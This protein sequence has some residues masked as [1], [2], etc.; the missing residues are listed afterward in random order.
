[1]KRFIYLLAAVAVTLLLNGCMGGAFDIGSTAP[2]PTNVRAIAGDSS[3]TLVWDTSPNHEYWL[4][5][6]PGTTVTTQNWDL[7]G[8]FAYPN[9]TSPYIAVNLT[10]GAPYAFTL[11]ARTKGGPGGPGSS[12][13]T[14]TPRLAGAAWNNNIALGNTDINAT[15]YGGVFVA[16]GQQGTIY[17]SP[18]FNAYTAVSWTAQANPLATPRPNLYAAIYGGAYVAAGAGGTLLY[19]TNATTWTQQTTGTSND[20]LGL[21][22]NG[23]GG[24]VAVG[25]NGTILTSVGGQTWTLQ[26]SGTSNDLYAISYGSGVWIAVGKSGA[27]LT[28]VNA[29]SWTPVVSGTGADINGITYG[30]GVDATTG[31]VTPMFIAVGAAGNQLTSTDNGATWRA[32]TI[33]Y[34]I[35]T[36]N[37]VSF[38]RQFVTVGNNGSIYSEDLR[39]Q[40]S[41]WH[42]PQHRQS[43][44]GGGGRREPVGALT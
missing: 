19:S 6:A 42:R 34:G 4:F 33:G 18:D 27:L 14:A 44:R 23:S 1:M 21:A 26:S 17:T 31:T 28:S 7:I 24:Y 25:R 15:T 29:I 16:V 30:A 10:N 20:L 37:A 22:S 39:H 3:V 11:N 40:Q 35:N 12:V 38:G 13:V 5:A 36:L 43:F 8:G 41:V 2:A 32:S 9:V